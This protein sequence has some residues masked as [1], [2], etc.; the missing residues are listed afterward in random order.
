MAKTLEQAIADKIGQDRRHRP[1]LRR[2]AADPG[3]RGRRLPDDGLRRRP[4]QGR[5]APGRQELHRAHPVASGSPSASTSGKFE[6]TADMTRLAEA[7]ALLI[8]VPTP[9]SESRDPDLTYIEATAATDRRDAAAGPAGRAGKHDLSRH[10]AR[11][12]AADPG[13]KRA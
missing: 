12:G 10:D 1:G 5:P 13:R 4:G 11:R 2:P 7:D 6:P 3:V 9:L 8:C